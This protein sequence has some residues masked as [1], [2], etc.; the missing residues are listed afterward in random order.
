[1]SSIGSKRRRAQT[2]VKDGLR[3]MAVQFSLLNNRVSTS[4]GLKGVDLECLDLIGR[5]GPLSPSALAQRAGMHPATLTGVLDRLERADWITRERDP[6]DRRGILLRARLDRAGEVYDKYGPMNRSLDELLENYTEE[7]LAVI[8][9]FV[10]RT[11][12][13]GRRATERFER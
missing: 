13:A 10:G 7:E 8:A 9:D 11:N 3:T 1:M 6:G 5:D 12:E 4:L 2:A